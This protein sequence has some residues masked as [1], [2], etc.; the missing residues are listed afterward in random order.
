MD[1][2]FLAKH[3]QYRTTNKDVSLSAGMAFMSNPDLYKS[4]LQ[5]GAEMIQASK[6]FSLCSK[7]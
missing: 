7:I 5:S 6:H 3:M 1:G 4:H 2:N